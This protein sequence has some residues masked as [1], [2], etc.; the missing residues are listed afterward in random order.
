MLLGISFTPREA[1][2]HLVNVKRTGNHIQ[3]SPF[4]INVLNQEIGDSSKVKVI[5]D[6]LKQG[7]THTE[8]EFI[9]DTKEAGKKKTS[10]LTISIPKEILIR[11]KQF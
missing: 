4:K 6:A 11:K 2:E 1:G 10:F 5:G 8:N 3:G 7:K 9:I